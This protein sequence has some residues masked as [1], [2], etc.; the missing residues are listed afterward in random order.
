MGLERRTSGVEELSLVVPGPAV[1]PSG[2]PQLRDSWLS[3]CSRLAS[4]RWPEGRVRP[5]PPSGTAA[6]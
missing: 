3:P 2:D 1:L 6:H 5:S 4:P